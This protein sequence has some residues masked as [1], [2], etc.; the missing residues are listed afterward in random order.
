MSRLQYK[1]T[2]DELPINDYLRDDNLLKI[3]QEDPWYTDIVNF[4]VKGYVPPG[5]NC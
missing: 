5:T 2:H 1:E 3:T 4:I